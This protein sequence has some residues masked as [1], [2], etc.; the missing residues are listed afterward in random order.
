MHF[1]TVYML[2]CVIGVCAWCRMVLPDSPP[3]Q[4]WG[5]CKPTEWMV[6]RG[7]PVLL[8]L[9]PSSTFWMWSVGRSGERGARNVRQIQPFVIAEWNRIA[10]HTCLRYMASMCS[11]CQA[12]IQANCGPSRY[13]S[14]NYKSQRNFNRYYDEQVLKSYINATEWNGS[15][16]V[17][18][19]DNFF[20]NR[21]LS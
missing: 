16:L 17:S 15:C 20:P 3:A 11:R 7:H 19:N 18:I 21:M 2:I 1:D 12:V 13:W 6:W 10:W 5:F 8:T 9:T 4:L 14:I